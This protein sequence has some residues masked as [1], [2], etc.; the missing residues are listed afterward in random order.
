MKRTLLR[1]TALA[2][3]LGTAFGTVACS[4][5]AGGAKDTTVFAAKTTAQGVGVA[6]Q[7]PLEDLNLKRVKIPKLLR[8]LET[9]YPEVP[10][11]TCFMIDFEV[12]ELNAVLGPDEDDPQPED[13]RNLL[14][15]AGDGIEAGAVYLVKDVAADQ[16]PFR[17]IVRRASGA[18]RHER[19]LREAYD[20]GVRRRTYLKGLGDAKGCDKARVNRELFEEDEKRRK[21]LGVF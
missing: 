5:V 2:L 19:K 16:I 7:V 9:A 1:L 21:F 6:A 15:K 11:E 18:T 4:T 20:L 10:P 8:D 13:D 3:A 17:S 14:D 12:R